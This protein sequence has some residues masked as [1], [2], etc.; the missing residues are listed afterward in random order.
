MFWVEQRCID[1][2]IL[3]IITRKNLFPLGMSHAVPYESRI[4]ILLVFRLQ[5]NTAYLPSPSHPKPS[6]ADH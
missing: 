4:S 1:V 2:Y 3:L 5:L 6:S